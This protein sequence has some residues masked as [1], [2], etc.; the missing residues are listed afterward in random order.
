[1]N[2]K[3][4]LKHLVFLMFFILILERIGVTLHWDYTTWWFDMVLHFLGGFWQGMLFIW[5]F[6]IKDLPLLKPPLDPHDP[7]LVYKT[8]FFVLLIGILWE[9]FQFYT[10]N[11]I[12]IYPFDIVDTTSDIFFDLAGGALALLYYFRRIMPAGKNEVQ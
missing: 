11:Y 8:I 5:F 12:G 10:K 7:K 1:M 2:R 3:K 6:S 4:L 9:L